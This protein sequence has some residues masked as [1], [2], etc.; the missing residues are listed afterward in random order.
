M[1]TNHPC[2]VQQLATKKPAENRMAPLQYIYLVV[3]KKQ[4]CQI[5]FIK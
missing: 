5:E 2:R 1:R 3:L 4:K